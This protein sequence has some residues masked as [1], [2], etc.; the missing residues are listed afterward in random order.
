MPGYAISCDT[1]R[2][3]LVCRISSA[4]SEGEVAQLC[5]DLDRGL[6][7]A[8]TRGPLRLLW[9]HRGL[10]VIVDGRAERLLALWQQ[11]CQVGD[12]I[13]ILV[14]HSL[15]KVLGKPVTAEEAAF[16]M[17]ENAAHTWL[18]IGASQAA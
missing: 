16:F 14:S 5:A 9:D 8:R 10:P 3:F 2:G 11:H 6:T 13:A 12:R 4:M 7:D 17:S 15:D 1:A 18:G